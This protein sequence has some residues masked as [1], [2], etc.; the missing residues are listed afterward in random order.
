MRKNADIKRYPGFGWTTVLFF[1]F[2]Y[3]P[4]LVVIV[5]SFNENK[6][7]TIWGG[8]S[9]KWYGSALT[10]SALISAAKVSLTVAFFATVVSTSVAIA[11]ALVLIRGKQVRFR[12]LS[13]TFINLPIM[14]PEIVFAVATLVL[15]SQFGLQHGLTK[16]IIAHSTFCIPFAFLPIRARLQ[17]MNEEVEQAARDLYA[18]PWD[19]FRLITL[20][21]ILPGVFAGAILAFIISMDDFITSNILGG[22]GATTLPVYIFSLVKQ[23]VSPEINAISTLIMCLSFM[24]GV[25]YWLHSRQ[26]RKLLT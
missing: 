17:G 12:R 1:L 22:G 19:T 8:F 16:L 3:I 26:K 24:I 21:L 6:I 14:L 4:I 10:N 5:Y 15:F 20:P 25:P 13:E 7:V 2:M 18:T 9:F 23:G 11:A